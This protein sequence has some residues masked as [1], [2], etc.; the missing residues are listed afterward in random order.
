MQ[1]KT[2]ET[3]RTRAFALAAGTVGLTVLAGV[4]SAGD[5][6]R[7][8]PFALAL[9]FVTMSALEALAD[10]QRRRLG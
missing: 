8:A 1:P 9:P 5:A 7:L 3:L 4:L 10:A 2:L 6:S